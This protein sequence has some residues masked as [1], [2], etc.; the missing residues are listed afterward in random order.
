MEVSVLSK[1]T[2]RTAI[3]DF[4]ERP[5]GQYVGLLV[6][7][8]C[9]TGSCDYNPYDFTLRDDDG[10]EFDTSFSNFEPDLNSGDLRKG[11]KAKGYITYELKPGK[12]DLEYRSNAF[13]GDVAVWRINVT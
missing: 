9:V 11:S 13:S 10:E 8:R 12:Y 7:Y 5:K 4:G 2:S 3:E 6:Q 1:K